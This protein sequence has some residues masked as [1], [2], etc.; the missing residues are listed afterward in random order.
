MAQDRVPLTQ[1]LETRDGTLTKDA[2]TYNGYFETREGKREFVKRPGLLSVGSTLPSG[3]AQGLTYFNGFLYAV[4]N[5]TIYKVDPTTYATTTVGTMTGTI[6]GSPAT[7]YFSQTL[8][9]GYL[10]IQNQVNAYL[11]NGSTGDITTLGNDKVQSVFITNGGTGY[12]SADTITF[13]D[14]PSGGTTATGTLVISGG[15]IT[16]VTIT[17]KGTGYITAP[18]LT[19]TTS[20]GSSFAGT[21]YLTFFP[22]GPL[23]P[24]AVFID[25]YIAVGLPNGRVY[26]CDVGDPTSW[27]ALSY[28][29]AQQQPDN[30][31]GIA[32]HLNYVLAFGQWS[33]EFFYDAGNPTG[34]PLSPANTYT[35]ELGCSN[36][37]SIVSFE[38]TVVWVG[39]SLTVGTGVYL[40][41]GVTPT[42]ISTN[43]VDRIINN[44]NLQNVKAYSIKVNG[45]T[46]YVLSLIDINKTIV[47]DMNEKQ[48]YPWTS[49]TT[50]T[51]TYG[52]NGILDEQF[53]KPTFFAGNG[54]KYFVLDYD[55]GNL[56]LV[57]DL[58]YTDNGYP[59]YYRIVTDNIDNGTS[60]RK[61]YSRVEILGDKIPAIMMIRHTE[62]DYRSWSN[63]R[64]VNLSLIRPQIS[65]CGSS[66]RRAWEFLCT[67]AKPLRLDC[68]EVT[69][70]IGEM[71]NEGMMPSNYRK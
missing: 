2:R 44:S 51:S 18:T 40:I 66:R 5:N 53:F 10:F 24:G 47:Y 36:G 31:V 68:A 27:N 13:S 41:D 9:N 49:Y 37:D 16:G 21:V 25:T 42:R 20:T 22:T 57:N 52:S 56:S 39:T 6:N 55:T 14:P 12:N 34:S 1:P 8:N 48:W 71:E 38:Q 58:Y 26:T 69:F 19:I 54:L 28:L 70:T 33:T 11:I 30:L 29:T 67:E 15:I 3:V 23:V 61:F 62:D 63:Y 35:I 60:K 32:R 46:L 59:I 43:Y 7:C 17:N 4:I 64:S 50:G 45:H 65:A